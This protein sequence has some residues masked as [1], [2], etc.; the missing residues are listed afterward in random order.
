MKFQA[1]C[2]LVFLAL[3]SSAYAQA[4]NLQTAGNFAVLAGAAVTSA[5]AGTTI[6]GS[7]GSSPTP[8]INGLL[9]AQV[10]GGTL[11]T[12][13]DA[14][15]TLAKTHLGLAYVDAAGRACTMTIASGEVGS[16]A[17]P[18]ISSLG[19]GV[20]CFTST[21]KLIGTLTLTGTST[22]VWIF[23]IGS[24]LTTA[25][26]ATVAFSGTAS[27]CN[28]FWQVTSS[29]TIETGNTFGGVIM[30]LASIT[31][32]GGTLTGRALART[33][34]V[35][36]SGKEAI[37]S[38]CSGST[39][40]L[41]PVNSA[42]VCG[43]AT[44]ITETAVAVSNGLPQGSTIVTFTITGPDAGQSGTATT[45][46]L[47]IA[48]F[49]ITSP[50]ITSSL[51]D[52]IQANIGSVLSNTTTATCSDVTP[53]PPVPTVN[54]VTQTKGPPKEVVLSVQA[55]GGL[56]SVVIDSSTTNATV[57]IAPFDTGTL[58][59]VGVTAIKIN[60]SASAVVELIVTDVFGQTT[61]FDPVFATITIPA[62]KPHHTGLFG[63]ATV[64]D[65]DFATI[66]ESDSDSATIPIPASKSHHVEEFDFNHREVA[67]F[68]GIGGTEGVV[69]LQND[70]L[71]VDFLVIRV[72]GHEFRTYLSDGE[73]KKLDISSALLHGP[74]SVTIVAFG[75]PGS[76][77]DLTISDGK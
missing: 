23:K 68:N 30:A 37:I 35:T 74:N 61:F 25:T 24:A 66:P 28:V 36:I 43:S 11:F 32:N 9:G 1:T 52:S 33:G 17:T 75:D 16:L 59:P 10:T 76:S 53:P 15:V 26:G 54:L 45:D 2:L 27:P 65:P 71:G 57:V 64:F 63:H 60:Q 49:T 8:T 31:L 7:V 19:P 50:S 77:V 70:T 6:V 40:V 44:S 5:D 21:A 73:T 42:T 48:T 38:G 29:A 55:P 67:R 51:G 39:I 46:A 12:A 47:G 56:S 4:P 69:L 20:Y 13:L 72:N 58:L 22:D 3:G 34:A 18:P 41:S 62:S 14:A